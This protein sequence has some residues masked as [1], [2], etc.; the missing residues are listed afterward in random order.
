[1]LA[2]MTM[3]LLSRQPAASGSSSSCGG[4]GCGG[5]G[6]GGPALP[7][8]RHVGRWNATPT[9]TP[10]TGNVIDGPLIG[11]GD[12]G[13]ALTSSGPNTLDFYLGK[14]DYWADAVD[15][16]WCDRASPPR[17]AALPR[18]GA[19]P[20]TARICHCSPQSRRLSLPLLSPGVSSTCT[21]QAAT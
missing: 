6:A 14:N 16:H 4:G 21:S 5:T 8:Q 17:R 19:A 11:N 9:M 20:H 18:A 7:V 12:A 15:Y 3:A 1:M 2:T 13:A 10:G